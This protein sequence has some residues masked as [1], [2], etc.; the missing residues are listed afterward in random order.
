M[1]YNITFK[2]PVLFGAF[3]LHQMS[4]NARKQFLVFAESLKLNWLE[5]RPLLENNTF[6][7]SLCFLNVQ[8][9][10]VQHLVPTWTY[11][12]QVSS[13]LS[14][15]FACLPT[16]ALP[17]YDSTQSVLSNVLGIAF[18]CLQVFEVEIYSRQRKCPTHSIYGWHAKLIT[19]I[20]ISQMEVPAETFQTVKLWW[21]NTQNYFV[22]NCGELFFLWDNGEH[23]ESFC[24]AH[25]S[26]V[27]RE[28]HRINQQCYR[29]V[30]II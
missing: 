2:H 16:L 3:N 11:D 4:A 14:T 24:V 13:Q 22:N 17:V 7:N 23:M 9:S 1:L 26:Q 27:E 19:H 28:L 20:S 15:K 6:A 25:D 12:V 5:A 18:S 21:W 8:K 29:N 10:F 30:T